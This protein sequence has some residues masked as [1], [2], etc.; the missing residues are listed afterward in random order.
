MLKK[1]KDPVSALTHFSGFIVAI[2]IL[3]LLVYKSSVIA[4]PWHVVS[5]AIFG[6]ALMGLYG[7]STVYHWACIDKDK[8]KILRRIDHMMIFVLIAG[9]YTP[10]CLVPLRGVW[11]WTL[12]ALV[13]GLALAG[14]I[15]KAVWLEAPRWLSTAIYVI[16]G[17][18]VVIAFF[19]L[20]KAIP[21]GGIAL[22]VAGG[23]TYTIGAIIY[24]TKWIPFKNKWFGAHELFHLFVMGG[25]LFH[26]IFMFQYVLNENII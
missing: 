8:E 26:I 11:G 13:W 16:M 3:I 6:L 15:L 1:I 24:A 18:V 22:L 23:V 5:F 25:S 20:T 21:S 14:I 12:L 17:W 4:T 7:A 9:T 19:P 10:V 2:P